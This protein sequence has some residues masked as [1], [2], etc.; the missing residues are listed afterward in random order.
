[1]EDYAVA[2]AN[3]LENPGYERSRFTIGYQAFRPGI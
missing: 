2:L 1:M 3:E